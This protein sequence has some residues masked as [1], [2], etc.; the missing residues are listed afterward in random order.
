MFKR[1][2]RGYNE[3]EVDDFLDEV[4]KDY[5]NILKERDLL[6]EQVDSLSRRLEQY[7][8]LEQNL[9]RALV[10]AEETAEEVRQNAKKE[11]EIIEKEAQRRAEGTVQQAE[12]RIKVLERDWTEIQKEIRLY[13]SRIR[14][15]AESM[16]ALLEEAERGEGRASG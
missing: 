10:V 11:S 16:I 13:K 14:G 5:E 4:T 8:Q 3:D 1:G 6:R 2:L 15:L 7:T 9:H 12:D